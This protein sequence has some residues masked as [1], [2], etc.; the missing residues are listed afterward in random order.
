MVTISP[1]K[2]K[3]LLRRSCVL[4][5]LF[6]IHGQMSTTINGLGLVH[7]RDRLPIVKG[8]IISKQILR[9]LRGDGLSSSLS[10]CVNIKL[11]K[12]K[13]KISFLGLT[14]SVVK[15]VRIRGPELL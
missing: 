6:N 2:K 7:D 4:D 1:K 8:C 9:A 15:T 11:G 3:K 12:I 14:D 5:I 13:I 10:L